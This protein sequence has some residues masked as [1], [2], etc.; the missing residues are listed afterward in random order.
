MA[1]V[2]DLIDFFRTVEASVDNER[3][4]VLCG[5]VVDWEARARTEFSA[6]TCLSLRE[7]RR[8]GS[9]EARS[10]TRVGRQG[11]QLRRRGKYW[12]RK[13]CEGGKIDQR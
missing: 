8:P 9:G 12:V 3:G 11:N 4:G 13:Y 6:I 5:K 1:N 2:V 7:R 10:G